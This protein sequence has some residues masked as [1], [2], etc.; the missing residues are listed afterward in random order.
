MDDDCKPGVFGVLT[1][2]GGVRYDTSGCI[3]AKPCILWSKLTT[4]YQRAGIW[5]VT[6]EE[7][8]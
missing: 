5:G 6:F 1:D 2:E 4:V 7:D 8:M 3:L